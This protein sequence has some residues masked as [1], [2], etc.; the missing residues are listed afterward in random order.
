MKC[1]RKDCDKEL[2]KKEIARRYGI[3]STVFIQD[4]CSPQCYTKDLMEKINNKEEIK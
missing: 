2:D 1:I 3:E 4:Y